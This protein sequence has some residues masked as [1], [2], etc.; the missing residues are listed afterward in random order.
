MVGAG[1]LARNARRARAALQAVGQDL[2]GAGLEGGHRVPRPRRPHRAAGAARLQP[3]RLRLHDLHRQLRPAAPEI[4]KAVSDADLAVVSVL[5]GNRNFEGRINPDVKMNYLASPP[6]CVAYALAGTMDID[7]VEEPL[8]S[9]QQGKDVYLRD[10]WPS[11]Q[12]MAQTI[13]AGRPRGHVPQELRRGV[14]RRRALERACTCPR[15]SASPGT[16]T[17]PTCACRPTS[18]TCPPS[19]RPSQD[20]RGARVLALLGDSVT[21]DHISPAGSIKRDSPA[22]AYL[23]EQG[24]AP[25]D[26]NS[27]G[28]RR[29]NHEVMVRGTFANIRLRNQLAPGARRSPE[30]GVHLRTCSE[31]ARRADADL[32]RGHALRAG[33]RPAGGA[34]GQGVRL[35]LLAR[36]GRQGHEAAWR[37]RGDRRELRA[38]PPLEPDRHGGAAAAVPRRGERA[39]ARAHRRG[40]ASRSSRPGRAA[41]APTAE[42]D[43]ARA[44]G[45]RAERAGG[46]RAGGVRCPR[47]HRHAA[48]GGVL[49]P[50]RDPPVRPASSCSPA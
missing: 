24:V 15:A 7:I 1:I 10:I 48:R 46:G 4:S 37:A 41:Q 14:R 11:E 28:S 36:L 2:A 13:G 18:R 50:R 45:V 22:G 29:G 8:G 6:L 47:A 44:C 34:R 27:Y 19:R 49:P 3:R 30:G 21:T 25:R 26:F 32:R 39:V 17:P 12:E 33:R 43:A 16:S 42:R 40:G 38:H 31:R 23:Q 5:S 35:R 9:D 20:V